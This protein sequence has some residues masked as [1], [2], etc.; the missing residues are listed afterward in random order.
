MKKKRGQG[1]KGK[2]GGVART[3][4][5]NNE[6]LVLERKWSGSS[7]RRLLND[8]N[9]CVVIRHQVRFIRPP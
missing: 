9:R 5:R 6:P 8:G 1:G 2:G 4:Q 3:L 7:L